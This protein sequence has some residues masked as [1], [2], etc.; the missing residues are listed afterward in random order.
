MRRQHGYAEIEGR[1]GAHVGQIAGRGP[2]HR[3]LTLEE[4]L[5]CGAPLDDSRRHDF[6]LGAQVNHVLQGLDHGGIVEIGLVAVRIH[7]EHVVLCSQ[8]LEQPIG[9]A[10]AGDT[11]AP[12]RDVPGGIGLGQLL[13][14]GD[15]FLP[16]RG[17]GIGI[18]PR[19]REGFLVPVE[20]RR[21]TLERHAIGLAAGLAVFHEGRIK[22][23]QPGMFR[24]RG[25]EF[26]E[27]NDRL[28]LDEGEHV[29]RQDHRELW[30]IAT[31]DRG[32]NLGDGVLVA[33]GIDRVDLHPRRL[34]DVI[35]R[36]TIDGIGRFAADRDR[37]VELQNHLRRRALYE[38]EGQAGREG[39]FGKIGIETHYWF[40]PLSFAGLVTTGPRFVP[41]LGFPHFLWRPA[42]AKIIA[43]QAGR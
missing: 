17:R 2:H 31:L 11:H 14:E 6:M 37:E 27:G 10:G 4:G 9:K 20:H 23:L 35:R 21:R 24:L 32:Q 39:G 29:H 1:I 5:G 3:G 22:P 30:R 8:A 26:L 40:L 7:H 15:H 43:A 34:T 19:F 16:G 42:G 33:A 38:A 12:L 28:F 41:R 25:E 36:Q 13:A 18:E